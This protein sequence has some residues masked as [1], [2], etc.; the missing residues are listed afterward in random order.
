[1]WGRDQA[2]PQ[3][4]AAWIISQGAV[5]IA[6]ITVPCRNASG[7]DGAPP[8]V[9]LAAAQN[10]SPMQ[11]QQ[12]LHPPLKARALADLS[13]SAVQRSAGQACK[14]PNMSSSES[15]LSE[16]SEPPSSDE[17]YEEEA[18]SAAE[19]ESDEGGSSGG[20]EGA[21]ADV[22]DGDNGAGKQNVGMFRA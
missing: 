5:V 9:T 8:A 19:S 2:L 16:A 18:E 12:D 13:L 6:S 22:G 20:E 4:S 7:Q 1:M 10:G 14:A 11:R 17:E 21:A 3:W 15:E